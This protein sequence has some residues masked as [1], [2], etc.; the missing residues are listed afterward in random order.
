[1]KYIV[2]GRDLH[3]S[4]GVLP[5]YEIYLQGQHSKAVQGRD[6]ESLKLIRNIADGA[7]FEVGS[8]FELSKVG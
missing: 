7:A 8:T 6:F 3:E 2:V 1:M 4:K 5:Y